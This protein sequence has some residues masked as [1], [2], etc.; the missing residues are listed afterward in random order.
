MFGSNTNVWIYLNMIDRF[1]WEIY[2]IPRKYN[3]HF[4]DWEIEFCICNFLFKL[5]KNVTYMFEI[6]F[7]K[8][9]L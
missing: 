6:Y 3:I 7:Y 5:L 9:N 2:K 4:L 8:Y 1:F